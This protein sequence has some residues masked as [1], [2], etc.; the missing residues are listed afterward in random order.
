MILANS[1]EETQLNAPI[2]PKNRK[3]VRIRWTV[4]LPC[5]PTLNRFWGA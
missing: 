2:L 1:E 4:S 3:A 5:L